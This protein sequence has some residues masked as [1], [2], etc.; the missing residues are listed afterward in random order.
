MKHLYVGKWAVVC[1]VCG[2]EYTADQLKKRWDG[3]MVCEKDFEHRH[4]QDFLRAGRVEK[5]LPYYRPEPEGVSV[6]PHDYTDYNYDTDY[7]QFPND[8]RY[9]TRDGT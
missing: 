9:T 3:L 1:D 6:S 7:D 8:A 2:F 4:E 5:P